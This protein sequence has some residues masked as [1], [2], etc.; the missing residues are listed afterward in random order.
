MSDLLCKFKIV[1]YLGI[2]V[3]RHSTTHIGVYGPEDG[4]W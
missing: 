4:E 2:K 1:I 3:L